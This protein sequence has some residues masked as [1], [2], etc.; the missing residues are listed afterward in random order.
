MTQGRTIVKRFE[1]RNMQT[2][3]YVCTIGAKS[4]GAATSTCVEALEF[5]SDEAF[6]KQYYLV[7]VYNASV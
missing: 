4:I 7:E 3:A 2:G 1:I 6:L 5:I